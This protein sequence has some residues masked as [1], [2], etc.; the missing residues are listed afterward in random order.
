MPGVPRDRRTLGGVDALKVSAAQAIVWHHFLSYG[1]MAR[2]IGI[3]PGSLAAWIR[4]EGA[5][6]VQVFLVI[7]GLLAA[8][9]IW[10]APG[11]LR[12]EPGARAIGARLWH[13]YLR[14]ARP[15]AVALV[16]AIACAAAARALGDDPDTPGPATLVQV[17]AHLLLAQDLAGVPALSTGVWYVS[18]DFQLY[19]VLLLLGWM[20]GRAAAATRAAAPAVAVAVLLLAV[21][22][23]LLVLNRDPRQDLWAGYFFGA[24]GLGVLAHWWPALPRRGL[25]TALMVAVWSAALLVQWRSRVALAGVVAVLLAA[26]MQHGPRLPRLPGRVLKRLSRA[27]YDLFLVHYPVLL[28]T[29][30]LVERMAP[31]RGD[32]ARVGLMGAWVASL[33]AADL[34]HRSVEAGG[35][36]LLRRHAPTRR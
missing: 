13:R 30:A 29:G 28:L 26:G 8:R 15:Y 2:S 27:S 24:Y 22:A 14:L 21:S 25:V 16:A 35:T 36:P 1:P 11:R 7:G 33:L 20:A 32:V 4:D 5:V 34:L 10:P 19:A 9:T 6:A 31:G 17:A 18:I 3:Q 12:G 23:S